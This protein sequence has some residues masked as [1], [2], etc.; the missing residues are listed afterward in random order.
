MR[1]F[2]RMSWTRPRMRER[3]WWHEVC[4]TTVI[5]YCT[6]L[7]PY[8]TSMIKI[9]MA[10][11]RQN[12]ERQNMDR[13]NMYAK[14]WTVKTWT[15]RQD[16]LVSHQI[17]MLQ[18]FDIFWGVLTYSCIIWK[19]N[20]SWCIRPGDPCVC[21]SIYEQLSLNKISRLED[22]NLMETFYMRMLRRSFALESYIFV[23]W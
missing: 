22:S 6:I 3:G 8:L 13:Q 23:L 5:F 15:V 12:M 9:V 2:F 18:Y 7:L 21:Y 14:T 11:V 20:K 17:K 19:C 1:C 16:Q 4:F 10:H